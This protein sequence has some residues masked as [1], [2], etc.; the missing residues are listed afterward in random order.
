MGGGR[1]PICQRAVRR[2][3][4]SGAALAGFLGVTTS[5]VNRATW[6]EPVS[7]IEACLEVVSEPTGPLLRIWRK[8]RLPVNPAADHMVQPAGRRGI[9]LAPSARVCQF[10]NAWL[11]PL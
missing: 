8:Y 10:R 11:S 5:T 4:C 3:G 2:L 7:G 9:G 6:A 1:R